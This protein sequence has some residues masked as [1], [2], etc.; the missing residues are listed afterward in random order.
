[1][2][3]PD[4]YISSKYKNEKETWSETHYKIKIF[5]TRGKYQTS[6]SNIIFQS[7]SN[8]SEGVIDQN[9]CLL[10][11]LLKKHKFS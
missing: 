1:M 9:V 4:Q 8:I 10:A 2:I 7:K 3:V 6:I 11:S 5:Y